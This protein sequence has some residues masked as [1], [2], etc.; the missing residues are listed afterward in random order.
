MDRPFY[1]RNRITAQL[2]VSGETPWRGSER[3]ARSTGQDTSV[4]PPS[5][6]LTHAHVTDIV[7]LHKT[8]DSF[9][10][11]VRFLD[12]TC[13]GQGAT[14]TISEFSSFFRA[15]R[16]IANWTERDGC[17]ITSIPCIGQQPGLDYV[18]DIDKLQFFR[19][20]GACG[21]LRPFFPQAAIIVSHVREA[22]AAS[23]TVVPSVR[24]PMPIMHPLLYQGGETD[25]RL[26]MYLAAREPARRHILSRTIDTISFGWPV[27]VAGDIS[28]L[29]PPTNL[30]S[31]YACEA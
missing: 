11:D 7:R 23:V 16:A 5:K 15:P 27:I 2:S 14:R 17:Y 31:R 3:R 8:N 4:P 20:L 13:R 26:Y 19:Q 1:D 21:G 25:R 29:L 6:S 10:S 9:A 22:P 30:P 12:S 28:S 18:M 24:R